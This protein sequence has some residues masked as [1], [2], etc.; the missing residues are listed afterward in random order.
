MHAKIALFQKRIFTRAARVV[1]TRVSGPAAEPV[2][3]SL[4]PPLPTRL[5]AAVAGVLVC[6]GR[7]GAIV[8]VLC[9]VRAQKTIVHAADGSGPHRNGADTVQQPLVTLVLASNTSGPFPLHRHEAFLHSGSSHGPVLR[10]MLTSASDD[11]GVRFRWGHR[12]T[13]ASS[14]PERPFAPRLN[15]HM[16]K[17]HGGQSAPARMPCQLA[18]CVSMAPPFRGRF[19][20]KVQLRMHWS[21]P[22]TPRH[23]PHSSAW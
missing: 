7:A 15:G 2:G 11:H 8:F 12:A 18:G 14:P 4:R 3:G 22:L 20:G 17:S 13:N 19:L 16:V 21:M 9:T 10:P 6:N 5:M 23:K 1:A